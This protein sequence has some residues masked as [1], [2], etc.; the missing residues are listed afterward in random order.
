MNCFSNYYVFFSPSEN[1]LISFSWSYKRN[2]DFPA[3][4]PGPLF[5]GI[6][7]ALL[8][9]A[10]K[11]ASGSGKEMTDLNK[12][13]DL[14][15]PRDKAAM[16][17]VNTIEFF[18]EGFTRKQSLAARGEKCFCS[19]PLTWPPW[20]HVQTSNAYF[21]HQLSFYP[22]MW[23]ASSGSS[24]LNCSCISFTKEQ[25]GDKLAFLSYG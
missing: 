20:R 18:L 14:M 9:P 15:Q 7:Y 23:N 2:N 3:D 21:Q 12:P 5:P 24:P 19:W 16:L 25:H 4:R 11:G 22:K 8:I 6:S 1:R 13:P 10:G 17:G